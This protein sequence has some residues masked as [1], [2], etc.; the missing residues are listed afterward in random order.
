M[1]SLP[2]SP[3]LEDIFRM[4]DVSLQCPGAPRKRPRAKVV[5]TLSTRLFDV[6]SCSTFGTDS[7]DS[8]DDHFC[9]RSLSIEKPPEI[10]RIRPVRLFEEEKSFENLVAVVTPIQ[11]SQFTPRSADG[12][13]RPSGLSTRT[14]ASINNGATS[15]STA[16]STNNGSTRKFLQT[17]QGRLLMMTREDV[18]NDDP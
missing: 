9:G 14:T 7:D 3:P 5:P 16:A 13:S 2:K 4:D 10:E 18:E 6:A 11:P 15:S 1:I 17:L 8:E 12:H